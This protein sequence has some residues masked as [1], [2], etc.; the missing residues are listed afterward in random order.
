MNQLPQDIWNQIAAE[1]KLETEA[2]RQAF[3]LGE[4][5]IDEMIE[6]WEAISSEDAKVACAVTLVAPLWIEREAIQR[7]LRADPARE[8][9][10]GVLIDVGSPEDAAELARLESRLNSEQVKELTAALKSGHALES[11]EAALRNHSRRL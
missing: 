5:E 9:L 4:E 1:Q 2:A 7:F 10:R 8:D 6:R 11:W 3:S